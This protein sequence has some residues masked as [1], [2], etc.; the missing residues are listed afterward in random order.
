MRFTMALI[1]LLGLSMSVH[2]QAAELL[3][4]H[5]RAMSYLMDDIFTRTGD[6]RDYPEGGRK[7][8]ELRQHLIQALALTPR[9]LANL[10]EGDKNAKMI[11]FHQLMARVIYLSASLERAFDAV[12]GYEPES[13]SRKDDIK[14]L[15]HEINAVSGQAH[16]H[17][18]D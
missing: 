2:G 18:Q 7:T 16:K 9:K 12:D 5:M 10:S 11:E 15:L 14:N 17:F 1:A 8:R 3:S 6:S 4:D 13:R